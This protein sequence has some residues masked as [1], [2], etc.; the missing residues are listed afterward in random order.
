MSRPRAAAKLIACV[1]CNKSFAPKWNWKQEQYCSDDCKNVAWL[2]RTQATIGAKTRTCLNC[3]QSFVAKYSSQKWCSHVCSR[4]SVMEVLE[5]NKCGTKFIPKHDQQ[6]YCSLNCRQNVGFITKQCSEC[7]EKF[8][9]GRASNLHSKC[10][11]CLVSQ[12]TH[13]CYG[14]GKT[15]IRPNSP[16]DSGKYCSHECY[17]RGRYGERTEPVQPE[18]K[19]CTICQNVVSRRAAKR[20]SAE[21]DKEHKRRQARKERFCADCGKSVHK[22]WKRR[23]EECDT[24]HVAQ[25]HQNN[26]AALSARKAKFRGASTDRFGRRITL[27]RLLQRD[28]DKCAI[29]GQKTDISADHSDNAYPSIDHIVPVSHGGAHIWSN[30]RVVHRGCNTKRGNRS[31]DIQMALPMVLEI[32][33]TFGEIIMT[34]V[35]REHKAK[36]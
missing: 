16:K 31:R 34:P 11:K 21:C 20:C 10:A 26:L 19:L 35:A 23:C 7:G 9:G 28:G 12:R 36:Q 8:G 27:K 15:F 22:N 30:V 6:K 5:C 24:R 33:G 2:T 3:G 18:V 13:I 1:I 17:I 32:R 4:K 29:C 25:N 14:C